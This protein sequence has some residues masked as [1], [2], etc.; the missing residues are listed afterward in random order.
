MSDSTQQVMSNQ[1]NKQST[2]KKPLRWKSIIDSFVTFFIMVLILIFSAN[3]YKNNEIFT[4]DPAN[5]TNPAIAI[6]WITLITLLAFMVFAVIR[7]LIVG[8][9]MVKNV[10]NLRD[11]NIFGKIFI[12]IF[13][14]LMFV[15]AAL[16]TFAVVAFIA[17]MI[18]TM[19]ENPEGKDLV[20]NGRVLMTWINL[21]DFETGV[22]ATFLVSALA[23]LFYI[24]SGSLYIFMAWVGKKRSKTQAQEVQEVV[25]K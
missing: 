11:R 3:F 16:L 21:G 12:P 25:N 8:I 15:L 18:K 2:Y 17:I 13:S 7:F 4:I 14:I 5:P 19:V 6:A 24:I 1:A 23:V 20:L 9:K 10:F 22:G